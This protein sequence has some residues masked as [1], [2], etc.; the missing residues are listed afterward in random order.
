MNTITITCKNC[1]TNF[2]GKFCN[3][4]GEKV[5]H[6]KDK[7]L[8]HF[9]EEG[10]HFMT[11]LEGTL[12][13]TL[14]TIFTKPGLLSVHYCEGVRKKYF[15]P[16]SLYLLLILIYLLF[17]LLPGL[18]M[19]LKYYPNQKFF[20]T[21]AETKINQKI[22]ETGYTLEK[23]SEVFH[24]KSEKTSRVLLIILI[25]LTALALHAFGFKKRRYFFDQMVL[26]AELNSFFLLWVFFIIP[27]VLIILN[28]ILKLV[29]ANP[30]FIDDNTIG[31]LTQA[32]MF[33]YI[34]FAA[35]NFYSFNWWQR[36]L[37]SFFLTTSHWYIVFYLYK[38]ILFIS[39]INQI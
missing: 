26:S 36:F 22:K 29:V 32:G 17:P 5:Y 19:N 14:K 38:F 15:K 8:L 21:Y 13:T 6:E 2:T 20:G 27:I 4:C 10:L 31:W 3:Q 35:K 18:N 23:L 16:L 24:Y 25:P 1:G 39:I 9:F 12:F 11:H 28:A 37:F 34:I 33:I 30:L 7:K